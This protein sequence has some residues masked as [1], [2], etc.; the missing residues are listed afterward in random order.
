MIGLLLNAIAYCY[1][2]TYKFRA[3]KMNIYN[4]LIIIFSL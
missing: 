4:N 3:E 2:N 1:K